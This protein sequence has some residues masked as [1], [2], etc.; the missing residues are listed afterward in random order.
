MPDDSYRLIIACPDKVGIVAAVSSFIAG[1][2]GLIVE[3]NHYLDPDSSWFFSRQVIAANSLAYG[4]TELEQRFAPMAAAFNMEWRIAATATPKR[5]VLMASKQ[6]HCLADLL[7]RWRSDEMA[8]EIAAV[9]SNHD[10]LRSY[11]EWHELP[12]HQVPATDKGRHFAEIQA[13]LAELNPD[14]IVLA[15]Y[16]QVLPPAICARYAGRIINIHH[17]FLPAFAGARPYHQA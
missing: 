3:A 4:L 7:Y 6:A 2:G 1:E 16:M 10:D 11:V 8:F 15:R 17:S 12:Y 9:I 5:V 14:V 13:L